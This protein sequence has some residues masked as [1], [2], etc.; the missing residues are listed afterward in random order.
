MK[1]T[2]LPK[3]LIGLV[4]LLAVPAVIQACNN[5]E[6]VINVDGEMKLPPIDLEEPALTETAT[7]ALG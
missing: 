3:V 6:E 7:F 5:E 2:R 4:V 1:N